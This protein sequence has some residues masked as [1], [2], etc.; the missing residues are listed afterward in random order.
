MAVTEAPSELT[1]CM[2]LYFRLCLQLLFSRTE[3]YGM[4]DFHLL[5]VWEKIYLHFR[6]KL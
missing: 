3:V 4:K 1:A 2:F 6:T 5:I